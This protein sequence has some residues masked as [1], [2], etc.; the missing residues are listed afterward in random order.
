MNKMYCDVKE[1]QEALG[2]SEG[3][4][5]RIIR[6]LNDELKKQGFI[7]VAGKVSRKYF[8][9]KCYGFDVADP[10]V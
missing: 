10:A 3:M 1:V 7:T 8:T 4:A 9:E 2:I 5:Y 6:Q